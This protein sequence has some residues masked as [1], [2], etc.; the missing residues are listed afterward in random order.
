MKPRI[1]LGIT[2]YRDLRNTEIAE[3]I[4]DAFAAVSPK[5]APN[6]ISVWQQHHPV[7][8]R[9]DFAQHWHTVLAYE[10]RESRA[11]NAPI[12][13]KG[14]YQV[15]AHWRTTGALNGRGEVSFQPDRDKTRP[16]TLRIDHA[17]SPRVDWYELL[18]RLV[19]ITE[20][21]YAMLHVF[22]VQGTNCGHSVAP[23]E[24][25]GALT[26]E[27]RFVSWKTPAGTWRKPDRWER[28]ERRRYRHL[29]DLPWANYLGPEFRDC[30]NLDQL[31]QAAF[32]SCEVGEGV[33]FRIT[34]QLGDVL[35][36]GS[37]FSERRSRLK[38]AFA[39]GTFHT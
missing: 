27:D 39:N 9:S 20:P 33:L 12:R 28:A 22:N 37:E 18:H 35:Q 11:K 13:D 3:Q 23:D 15:G 10:I 25:S 26:G 7:A 8:N 36:A 32:A 2:T 16:D 17:F 21:A 31:R 29:P 1:V 4:Y 19:Q 30:F 24:F 14:N 6:R 34:S 5:L 38:R